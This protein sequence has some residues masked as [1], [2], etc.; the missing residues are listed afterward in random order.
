[1]PLERAS[2]HGP[3]A[4]GHLDQDADSNTVVEQIPM[5][6][7]RSQRPPAG[8]PSA[9]QAPSSS[10]TQVSS[11]APDNSNAGPVSRATTATSSTGNSEAQRGPARA[12]EPRLQRHGPSEMPDWSSDPAPSMSQP[13]T[14]A[15]LPASGM[16]T[17][18]NLSEERSGGRIG[19]QNARMSTGHVNELSH[20][21]GSAEA[22]KGKSRAA[23]VEEGEDEG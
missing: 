14:S 5:P 9:T 13:Y 8:M 12:P 6:S 20:A 23:T 19:A 21:N 4:E 10:D 17:G 11:S 22:G 3:F 16:D 18:V 1:M 2:I 15:N 7:L